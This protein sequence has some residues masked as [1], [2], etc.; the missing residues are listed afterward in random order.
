MRL[1]NQTLNLSRLILSCFTRR[2]DKVVFNLKLSNLVD[3]DIPKAVT[4]RI[5]LGTSENR[6]LSWVMITVSSITKS[7]L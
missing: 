4:C 3:S 6:R 1:L 7:Y 2:F 5:K